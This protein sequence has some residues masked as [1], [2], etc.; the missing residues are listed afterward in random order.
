M[1]AT[2]PGQGFTYPRKGGAV[3]TPR[4]EFPGM[5]TQLQLHRTCPGLHAELQQPRKLG[6]VDETMRRLQEDRKRHFMHSA[7]VQMGTDRL[8]ANI[9]GATCL[10]VF[11]TIVH[12]TGSQ[13]SDA[14]CEEVLERLITNAAVQGMD[15]PM[16]A[17]SR[18]AT[19]DRA[20]RS[21]ESP[22]RR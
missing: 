1:A 16:E 9:Q 7:Q 8:A 11:Q 2:A 13:C 4:R 6:S 19:A 21:P 20:Y 15:T 18:V 3:G 5:G 10:E 17:G 12:E 22:R 14:D